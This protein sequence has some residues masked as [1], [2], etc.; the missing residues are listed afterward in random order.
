P[1]RS[2]RGDLPRRRGGVFPEARR[3]RTRR[4]RIR[5]G[6]RAIDRV[7]QTI[8]WKGI[9]MK[10]TVSILCGALLAALVACGGSTKSDTTTPKQTGDST[11]TPATPTEQPGQPPSQPGDQPADPNQQPQPPK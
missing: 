4:A 9:P 1:H 6:C 10:K 7:V 11:M 8:T 3:A 2:R 5:A